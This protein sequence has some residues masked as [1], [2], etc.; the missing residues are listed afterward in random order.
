M[1]R[2]LTLMIL[3]GGTEGDVPW[4]KFEKKISKNAGEIV[5]LGTN[6]FKILVGI[7]LLVDL[8]LFTSQM[9]VQVSWGRICQKLKMS[10][11]TTSLILSILR[12][13]C[14]LSYSY[15]DCEQYLIAVIS[16]EVCLKIK[17]C[18]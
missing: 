7:S 12:W 14:I 5:L 13:F 4:Y 16:I 9:A 11:T 3:L 8:C 10:F 2:E 17:Q 1:S 6:V 15:L 18:L